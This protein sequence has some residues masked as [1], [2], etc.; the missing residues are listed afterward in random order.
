[1]HSNTSLLFFRGHW[2][3]NI[4]EDRRHFRLFQASEIMCRC[5]VCMGQW[6]PR[7]HLRAAA[8]TSQQR[9]IFNKWN[10][11]C[12]TFQPQQAAEIFKE[13]CHCLNNISEFPQTKEHHQVFKIF[14]NTLNFFQYS[15]T[16]NAT[17]PWI[18]IIIYLFW[19]FLD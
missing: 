5:R 4:Y 3:E 11:K 9:K 6:D 18:K 1:M 7:H 14:R 15:A 12:G 19:I 13:S 10:K 2:Y 8:L 16:G 17:V